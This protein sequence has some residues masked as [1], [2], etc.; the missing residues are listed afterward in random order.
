MEP[1][2]SPMRRQPMGRF[3]IA[4]RRKSRARNRLCQTNPRWV[5]KAECWPISGPAT[6]GIHRLKVLLCSPGI[7]HRHCRRNFSAARTDG[8]RFVST[9]RLHRT[10][11][12]WPSSDRVLRR[13]FSVCNLSDL[14][15]HRPVC[16]QLF[17]EHFVRRFSLVGAMWSSEVVE[18]LPFGQLGFQI[19]V[20]LVGEQ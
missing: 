16:L 12:V 11:R 4:G 18:A 2:A 13:E 8:A 14:A 6:T 5:R 20:A 19:N 15:R 10:K 7:V 3:G 17:P 9:R 1:V